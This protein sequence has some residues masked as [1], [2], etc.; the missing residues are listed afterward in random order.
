MSFGNDIS[1]P[2]GNTTIA[3]MENVAKAKQQEDA[4]EQISSNK[5][6]SES[7]RETVNPMAA[8]R[9]NE[10]TVKARKAHISK[11]LQS[12]DKPAALLPIQ[13]IKDMAGKFQ[14]R[15]PELREKVLVLLRE[16][17][18]PGDTKDDILRKILEF[19]PD[20]PSLADEALEFLL[21]TTEG[22]LH[23]QV[24]QA[25]S[26]HLQQFT[27]EITAGRNIST[28]TNEAAQK[29]LGTPT[30]LRDLYKDVTANPRDA[31]M[32]FQELSQKYN[33]DFNQINKALGFLLHS[34][35]SDMKSKGPSIE[36]GQLQMLFN[37][38]RSLQ[39][40]LGVYRF[41]KGRTHLVETLFKKEGV[42]MPQQLSFELM[43]KQFMTLAAERYPT[44]KAVL[45]S[46]VPLGVKDSPA[47]I[48]TVLSQ[49][50]D[51]IYQV[52]VPQILKGDAR[53]A[54]LFNAIIL[55]L[56]ELEDAL[57]EL[58]D[59]QV[60]SQKEIEE[61]MEDQEF[62]KIRAGGSAPAA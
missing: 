12:G 23:D 54:E 58:Q 16:Y 4:S 1:R 62:K 3:A 59:K 46:V 2:V 53:K 50:R 48:I 14:K 29:G 56:D 40:I 7:L 17:L 26:E 24:E 31:T 19:Y 52:S 9:K 8:L 36:P 6:I 25:R 10:K 21:A 44:P 47:G 5:D 45:D 35:G 27:R 61:Y 13:Q 33:S 15:N 42:D 38:T 28:Q 30:T 49:F 22:D 51:A 11:L 57:D 37:E 32:L 18:K 43:T 20:N 34:L 41:F 55:A 39:S 60:N